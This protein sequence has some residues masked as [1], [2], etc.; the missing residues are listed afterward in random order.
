MKRGHEDGMN[1]GNDLY[2]ID[3]EKPTGRKEDVKGGAERDMQ[4]ET[5]ERQQ[6][7]HG[8]RTR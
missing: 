8:E 1:K 4:R 7:I 2:Y 5:R 6:R 3:T